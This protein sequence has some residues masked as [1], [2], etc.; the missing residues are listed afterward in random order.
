MSE[1]KINTPHRVQDR[2]TPMRRKGRS[3]LETILGETEF[4]P[5][6]PGEADESAAE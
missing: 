1:V 4:L 3:G 5:H 2:C 6:G